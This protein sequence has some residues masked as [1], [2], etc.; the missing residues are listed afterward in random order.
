MDDGDGT[1]PGRGVALV[2][3]GAEGGR[4]GSLS[5]RTALGGLLA[6]VWEARALAQTA[7]GGVRPTLSTADAP[8]A[9]ARASAPDWPRV[10]KTGETTL[11][12]YLPQLDSWDGH[13]LEAHAAVSIQT[14]ATTPAGLR[15]RLARPRTRRWTRA[16]AR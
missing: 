2:M 8:A 12:L 6:L 4:G 15:R 9:R 1:G 7:P 11:S 10:I 3:G 13:R 14:S 5:R 16:R